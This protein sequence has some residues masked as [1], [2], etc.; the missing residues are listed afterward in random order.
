MRK[1]ILLFLLVFQWVTLN[2]QEGTL[3]CIHGFMANHRSM[4]TIAKSLK[5]VG[6]PVYCWQYASRQKTIEEHACS[7]IPILQEISCYRPGEPINFV[8]H[9][10]G[11]LI[12]RAAL[13]L[14]D[15]PLEA[16]IGRAA[17]IAP[18]NQG[19]RLAYRFRNFLPV[20]LAMGTKSGWQ[21]M[22]YD[23]CAIER[24]GFFPDTM[25]VLVIAGT[26]GRSMF[27]NEPNDG[28]I[29]IDE[30]ALDTPYYW[31]CFKLAHGELLKSAAV[32]CTLRSFFCYGYP[33]FP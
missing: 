25:Q 12:L 22:H 14:P 9:S 27:I 19:S 21:I 15:C 16:K 31:T 26:K 4:H 30:T 2:A 28:F 10:I 5:G 1:G 33:E 32:L 8:T 11:A 23:I 20:K 3:V 18:P 7:L 6:F 17:L 24:F 29:A 13:N